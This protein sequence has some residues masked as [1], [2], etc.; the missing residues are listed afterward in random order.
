MW[1]NDSLCCTPNIVGCAMYLFQPLSYFITVLS[2]ERLSLFQ[3][4]PSQEQDQNKSAHISFGN[5][6]V[7]LTRSMFHKWPWYV[8]CTLAT[9]SLHKPFFLSFFLLV[10]TI[11][12]QLQLG[13]NHKYIRFL[14]F[15]LFLISIF[16]ISILIVFTWFFWNLLNVGSSVIKLL[17]LSCPYANVNGASILES[18]N[19]KVIIKRWDCPESF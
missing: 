5:H 1:W 10:Q 9:I 2:L 8:C 12:P 6:I 18:H 11:Q 4:L 16:P 13:N 7:T 15:I 14:L 17:G 3:L 19:M